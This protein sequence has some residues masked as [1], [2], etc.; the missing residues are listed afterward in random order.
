[1]DQLGQH[2]AAYARRLRRRVSPFRRTASRRQAGLTIIELMV[3]M[4]VLTFGMLAMLAMQIHAMRGGTV[5]R[6]YTRAAR[7]ARDQVE[8]FHRFPY[9]DPQFA[10]TG[11]WVIGANVVTDN[12]TL[13]AAGQNFTDEV[14][15]VDWRLTTNPAR[16]D[17]RNIDVRVTWREHNDDA[18]APPR[19]FA[20]SSSRYDDS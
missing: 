18:G 11:G 8:V 4:V 17:L 5:G 13:N 3:A 6:H 7:I 16:P 15:T 1:M 20:I 19:R 9:D 10:D 12:I 14:Y 2:T